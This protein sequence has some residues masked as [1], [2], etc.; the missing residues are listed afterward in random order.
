MKLEHSQRHLLLMIVLHLLPGIKNQLD[1]F[2]NVFGEGV[3]INSLINSQIH[4]FTNLSKVLTFSLGK[5]FNLFWSPLFVCTMEITVLTSEFY[6]NE[7][8]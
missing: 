3:Y 4:I 1:G 8:G 6:G 5:L 2:K 7:T